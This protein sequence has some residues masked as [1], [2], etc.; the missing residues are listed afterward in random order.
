MRIEKDTLKEIPEDP[1]TDSDVQRY[2]LLPLTPLPSS[3]YFQPMTRICGGKW[4]GR[5]L[6]SPSGIRLTSGRVKEAL[7]SMVDVEGKDFLDLF[8]GS[9]A[10]GIEALSR[11]AKNAVFVEK[12]REIVKIIKKNLENL[13]G[14]GKVIRGDAERVVRKME[15]KFDV[16]FMDPPYERGYVERVL[17]LLPSL[18]REEG[19]IVVEHSKRE[20]AELP[21]FEKKEK[22]YDDTVLTLF[23]R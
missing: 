10:V 14:V 3:L 6:S 2:G 1:F 7:F 9:G 21:G 18:L 17:P 16:I 13:G 19:I 23:W 15:E 4:K 20:P 5:K 8:A 12:R 22:I 11:G